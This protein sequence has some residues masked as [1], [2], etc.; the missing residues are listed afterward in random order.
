MYLLIIAAPQIIETV[1]S[2]G[3]TA[4]EIAA[5][6][7]AVLFGILLIVIIIVCCVVQGKSTNIDFFRFKHFN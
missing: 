4:G 2:A 7:L 5:I 6:C 1:V 3:L